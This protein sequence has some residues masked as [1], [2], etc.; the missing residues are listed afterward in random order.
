MP[1]FQIFSPAQIQSLRKG[2]SILRACLDHT[3]SLVRPGVTT[4]ELDR[5]A[6]EFIRSHDG[7][8]PAFKGYRGFPATLCISINDECVHGIPGKRVIREG[9]LV[10]LDCGVILDNLYTDAAVSVG[11]G[12]VDKRVTHLLTVTNGCL[13]EGVARVKPGAHIGDISQAV[14]DCAY[15]GS[16]TPIKALTGHGLG[17]NLHQY[18]D[19]P[20]IGKSGTGPV[21]P[22]WTMIAIEPIISE[23]N[24]SIVTDDDGWTIRTGDGHLCSHSEHSVLVTE[25]GHEIIA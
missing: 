6:E 8:R 3:S 20:N 15:G 18:P 10:S 11:A 24:G 13:D 9:D 16:C 2:G 22:A 25:D 7:A 21:L 23:G 17:T 12:K 19:V 14:Q 4:A 1:S 5:T